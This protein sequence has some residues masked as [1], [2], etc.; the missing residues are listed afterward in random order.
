MAGWHGAA[1]RWLWDRL[2]AERER[3]V[4]WAPVGVGVGIALYFALPVEP[5]PWLGMTV[6]AAALWP[7]VLAGRSRSTPSHGDG[8]A[9]PTRDLVPAAAVVVAV[10]ATG[11]TAAQLRTWMVQAPVL[12]QRL[13]PTLI[14]GQ[15][16]RLESR[17]TGMRI[18][19]A[20][21]RIRDLPEADT[22]A[23]VRVT[24]RGEQ[25]AI[26]PGDE[27]RL[28]GVLMPPPAP[29]APGAFDF[30]RQSFYQQLGAVGFAYGQASV[31]AHGASADGWSTGI[32]RLR[33]HIGERIR[34]HLPG[35]VG[36]VATALMTGE[37]G[38]IPRP[39]MTAIRES[40]LAHLLAISGLHIG[41]VAG[42]LFAATR[43]GLALVPAVALRFPIKKWAAVI[44]LA[45][46]AGY[47]ALAGASVPT[48]RSLLMI[49]LVLL[50]VMF[51]RRGLSMRA[52]VWAALLILL[53]APESLLTASFQLSFAAVVALIAVYEVV[54]E[55]RFRHGEERTLPE[56]V[57]LYL[58]GVALTTIVAGAATA[59]FVMFHFNQLA[60]YGL[61]ANLVAVPIT[62][63]WVMPW[64]VAAFIL[65]PFGLEGIALAP[66]GWGLDPVLR[67]ADAVSR[68]PGAVSYWP[69][70][71]VWALAMIALGGAWLCLWRTR[72]RLF[73]IIPIAVGL[74]AFVFAAP[75]D[76]LIDGEG[77]LVATRTETGALAVSSLRANRFGR[78]V[79]QQRY[80]QDDE[81][82]PWPEQGYSSD[83]RMTCDSLG[84]IYRA[85]G[86]T[87]A[88]AQKPEALAEDCTHAD[89]VISVV[90][91]R[92]RCTSPTVTIDRFDLWRDGAHA[93][94]LSEERIRVESVNG[95]RGDRP[96]VAR[97]GSFDDQD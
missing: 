31:L 32:A 68:W 79:W 39:V 24:L 46:A 72:W 87:V 51:D 20:D 78:H 36:A 44:A 96:W 14:T 97:S 48:Q 71:P 89:L 80:S 60:G 91:I 30:Q 52:V 16:D 49:G 75:P 34:D 22:P 25:P 65:M 21:V 53:L 3:W 33:Q 64:A 19:L 56:R 92:I 76:V 81:M 6:L 35:T 38:Q 77:D 45:G 9:G 12:Q 93:I 18:T 59:P 54:R 70:A 10:V 47:A 40:G 27:V 41:L 58:G 15:V 5:P 37:R 62:A 85:D 4:L 28:R 23:R 63:L 11:F 57:L 43:G 29:A 86:H 42:V 61:A 88:I 67:V 55:L 84:C 69:A 90:P 13:G 8:R 83:G 7:L 1:A 94:W 26:R 50:A 82:I 66:M 2:A 17:T 73:G 74:T 95:R